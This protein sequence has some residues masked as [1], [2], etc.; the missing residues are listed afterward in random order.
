MFE[1][2]LEDAKFWKDCVD[3]I[4]NLIDEGVLEVKPEG[5]TLK[6][7]DSSQ[8]AMVSFSVPKSSFVSYKVESAEKIGLNFD[9]LGKILART[10]GKERLRMSSEENRLELDFSDGTTRKFKVPLL[11][12]S[13]GVQKE[14]K[15]EYDATVKINGGQFKEI[16]RDASLV[17]SHIALEATEAGFFV[18]ARGDSAD[19]RVENA[20]SAQ[21]V[22]EVQARK[23]A[24][25]TFPLQ[26]LD[27]ISKSCPNEGSMTIHLKNNAPVK[28]EYAIGDA[29]LTYY[30]APRID[31]A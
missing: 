21:T 4:V 23:P 30:L 15:I 18:E 17:S 19:M 3:A 24:R 14:P 10:R 26:F 8:I 11:D 9:N 13:V 6:A 12:L 16:L 29:S 1:M 2:E 7:M 20:K 5:I 31:V 27:D 28:V 25:A 22:S